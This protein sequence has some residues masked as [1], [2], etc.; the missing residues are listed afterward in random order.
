[1]IS[2]YYSSLVLQL[3]SI[4]VI[5]Y[6]FKIDFITKYLNL[7]Y[8]T[9]LMC[10]GFVLFILYLICVKK[11]QF[12]ISFLL[13][14]IFIHFAPLYITYKYSAKT[15]MKETLF[16][17]V[18]IYGLIMIY[19]NKNPRFE[20]HDVWSHEGLLVILEACGVDIQ[21]QPRCVAYVCI[22]LLHL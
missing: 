14:L 20:V 4:W 2:K 15:Y 19:I 10:G 9:I 12:E 6:I 21:S 5:G 17:S 8:A 11:E 1:M 22:V 16:I 7:Y 18:I 13:L 3:F